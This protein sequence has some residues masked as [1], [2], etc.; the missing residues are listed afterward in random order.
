MRVYK[1]EQITYHLRGVG[2][3]RGGRVRAVLHRQR[4]GDVKGGEKNMH[5]S[6]NGGERASGSIDMLNYLP[7]YINYYLLRWLLFLFV[8][9]IALHV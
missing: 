7:F 5:R 1:P 9:I 6:L 3:M 2:A 8:I 4:D